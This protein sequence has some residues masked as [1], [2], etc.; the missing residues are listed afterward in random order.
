[1]QTAKISIST[2]SLERGVNSVRSREGAYLE[3][4]GRTRERLT[5]RWRLGDA[6]TGLPWVLVPGH[7]SR[8]DRR[9]G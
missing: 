7:G 4:S 6:G 2:H 5:V 3:G 8:R 1:M 9:A